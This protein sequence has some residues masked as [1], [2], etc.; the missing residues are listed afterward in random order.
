M[1]TIEDRLKKLKESKL[2]KTTKS[3]LMKKL[4]ISEEE[5]SHFKVSYYSLKENF[6]GAQKHWRDREIEVEQLKERLKKAEKL[7][8]AISQFNQFSNKEIDEFINKN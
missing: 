5:T 6:D 4:E 7:L 1:D 3:E 2:S 8:R